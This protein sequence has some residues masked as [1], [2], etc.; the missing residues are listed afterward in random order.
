MFI[1]C[2]SISTLDMKRVLLLHL[3]LLLFI[4]A[5]GQ[6]KGFVKDTNGE[7]LPYAT[8]YVE[9]SSIGTSTNTEGYFELKVPADAKVLVFQ[10]VGYI[11]KKHQLNVAINENE[12]LEIFLVVQSQGIEQVTISA[13]A[14]DPAYAIIRNAIAQREKNKKEISNYKADVYIKGLVRIN[15]APSKFMGMNI[16]DMEGILDSTRNGIVYLSES[17]STI[18]AKE[19]DKFKEV[20]YASKVSGDMDAIS[21][22]QF[23]D[24]NFSFYDEFI[25]FNRNLVS[26]LADQAF[27]YY[28]FKLIQSFVDERG[29]QINK[30]EVIPKSKND[31]IFSGFIYIM[32]DGWRIHS[33]DLSTTGLAAKNALFESLSFKQIYIPAENN[34][35]VLFSQI[36]EFELKILSFKFNGYNT[37]FLSDYSFEALD[38]GLF[39]REVFKAD[40]KASERDSSFWNTSR[41]ISITNEEQRDYN[42]KDSLEVLWNSETYR[43]SVDRASNKFKIF[44]LLFGYTYSNSFDKLYISYKSPLNS[45]LFNA[46]QGYN[47]NLDFRIRKWNKDQTSYFMVEPSFNYGFTEKKFRPK[48]SFTKLYDALNYPRLSFSLGRELR[49]VNNANPMSVFTNSIESLFFKN[50]YLKLYE[51]DFVNLKFTREWEYGIRTGIKL[52]HQRRHGLPVNTSFSYRRKEAFYQSN[53]PWNPEPG[54]DIFFLN[55]DIS[56]ISIDLRFK[57]KQSYMT[58]GKERY[59]QRS[60]WPDFVLKYLGGSSFTSSGSSFNKIQLGIIDRRT[61]LNLWGYLSYNFE[62]GY[63]ISKKNLN[64]LDQFH[65]IGNQSSLII[66]PNFLN[67]FLLL[68]DYAL[69]TDD[70]YFKSSIAFHLEGKLFDKIPLLKNTGMS[71]VFAYRQV[72][73]QDGQHHEVS[74]GIENIKLFGIPM[75]RVDYAWTPK[76]KYFRKHGLFVS[77]TSSF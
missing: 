43:D 42:R 68:P 71:S 19:P 74:F 55:D 49:Q 51:A 24:V 47:A 30:I 27:R 5:M 11:T 75:L 67:R 9:N 41:P 54:S 1:P 16:G 35:W 22:N 37:S 44:D 3:L 65:F 46:I 25:R 26:P 62:A 12:L 13:N 53:N 28:R 58:Y 15:D 64:P 73:T 70:A 48:V 61:D 20:M 32:D 56:T 76:N 21:F 7:A 52:E 14:E 34:K 57:P 45:L 40:A 23:S 2:W 29:Q 18:Y 63:F 50:H 39:T 77:S 33:T 60:N 4:G 36:M 17:K 72:Q 69:S 10:Y 38:D 31:P 6:V 59:R 66:D 8:I